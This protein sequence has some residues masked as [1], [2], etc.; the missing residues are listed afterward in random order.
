MMESG[1]LVR[2]RIKASCPLVTK[3]KRNEIEDCNLLNY[4][5]SALDDHTVIKN[6]GPNGMNKICF[7][8]YMYKI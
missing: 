1:T 5:V 6:N 8:V 4:S 2:K 7:K 3:A